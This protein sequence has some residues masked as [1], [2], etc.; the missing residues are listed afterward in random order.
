MHHKCSVKNTLENIAL[1]KK[2]NFCN[3]TINLI[4]F[5][6]MY[7]WLYSQ[8]RFSG[9]ELQLFSNLFVSL[10]QSAAVE[11]YLGFL[12]DTLT[13][14]SSQSQPMWQEFLCPQVLIYKYES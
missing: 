11:F 3:D 8:A 10:I 12:V 9:M 7:K 1:C 4:N 6:I 5:L 13:K 14:S 2:H